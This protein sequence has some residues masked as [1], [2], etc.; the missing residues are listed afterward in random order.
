[1]SRS[2]TTSGG[3]FLDWWFGRN[4]IP[5][6]DRHAYLGG[7]IFLHMQKAWS[8]DTKLKLI[9]TLTEHLSF[10]AER[11]VRLSEQD[12]R[13][14]L[15]LPR[16]EIPLLNSAT[17]D[18][19]QSQLSSA[20]TGPKPA[21]WSGFITREAG[22]DTW[23]YLLRF[24]SRDIWKIGLTQDVARRL[25]EV[26]QH[27]PHEETGERWEVVLTMRWSTAYEAYAMEQAVL[28]ALKSFRSIGE[29]V[30]CSEVEIRRVWMHF[31]SEM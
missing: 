19:I 11:C 15:A 3:R 23:T 5:S 21:D 20:T 24:G 27:V 12:S 18:R 17:I 31:D 7:P 26:N 10:G 14:V 1:M 9:D 13:A 2:P 4:P 30:S 25:A 28:A 29:R 22:R 8:F 6:I 16:T